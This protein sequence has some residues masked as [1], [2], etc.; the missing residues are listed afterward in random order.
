MLR[1]LGCFSTQ[2]TYI[3]R[4]LYPQDIEAGNTLMAY[5]ILRLV[6][7]QNGCCDVCSVP[8]GSHSWIIEYVLYTVIVWRNECVG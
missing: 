8:L 2:A 1:N 3:L 7:P 6:Q 4:P 5:A